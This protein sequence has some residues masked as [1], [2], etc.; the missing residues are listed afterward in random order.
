MPSRKPRISRA[1]RWS[2]SASPSPSLEPRGATAWHDA[3]ANVTTLRTC[4]QGAGVMRD[5]LSNFLK[6]EKGQI[7]VITED[8]GGAFGMK[9]GVYPEYTALIAAARAHRQAGALD[10]H[11][12]GSV[13]DRQPGP[14]RRHRGR[15]RARRARKISGAARAASRQYGRL[16]DL[17]RRAACDL[18]FLALL[19]DRLSCAASRRDGALHLHAYDADRPLSRRRTAGIELSDGAHRRGGRARHRHRSRDFAQAQPH[20]ALGHSV[21]DRRAD[22]L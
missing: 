13:L 8:V 20:S 2:I 7:R 5:A 11:A 19:P 21:Q 10:V 6:C 3:A 16:H 18:Q 1:S 15:A 9:T 4:S 22:D 17:C 14:R 12:L